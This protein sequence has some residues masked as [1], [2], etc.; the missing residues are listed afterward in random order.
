[1]ATYAGSCHCGRIA[2]TVDGEVARAIDCNCSLCRRRG[3]LLAFFPRSAFTL[4]TPEAQAS[5]YTF[6]THAIGHRFCPVC[7]V[8]PYSEG[9]DPATGADVVAV[10]LR[11]L[12][13]LDLSGLHIVP[14]DGAS[15]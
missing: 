4:H 10:N 1:M 14:F 5:L 9:R 8:A 7:G 15:R 3:G 2:F 13:E 11:C 12:P 6:N